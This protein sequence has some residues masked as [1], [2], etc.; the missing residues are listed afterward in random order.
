MRLKPHIIAVA[1][2]AT[3]RQMVDDYELAVKDKR[4][5]QALAAPI[6]HRVAL[7][8]LELILFDIGSAAIGRGQLQAFLR[9]GVLAHQLF[10]LK[11]QFLLSQ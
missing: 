3:L 9:G 8:R 5:R 4:Q 10:F 1:S 6:E 2:T 11:F 7:D